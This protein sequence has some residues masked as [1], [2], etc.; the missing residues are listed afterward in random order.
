MLQVVLF[1]SPAGEYKEPLSNGER[2][3]NTRSPVKLS[4]TSKDLLV[5]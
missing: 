1:F 2:S 5:S 4:P 3:D